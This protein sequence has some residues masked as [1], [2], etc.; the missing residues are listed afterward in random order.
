V[1]LR[2]PAPAALW[3]ARHLLVLPTL[4]FVSS[5]QEMIHCGVRL[6]G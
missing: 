3:Q 1:R 6:A 4:L 2:T 5:A